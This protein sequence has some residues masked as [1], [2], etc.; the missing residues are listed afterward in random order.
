MKANSAVRLIGIN[1]T[2]D[3]PDDFVNLH[4]I[5]QF[6][7]VLD[8]M[9]GLTA[10]GED[11]DKAQVTGIINLPRISYA[12]K[13]RLTARYPEVN[14]NAE[15]VICC[16]QFMNE[17]ADETFV[18]YEERNVVSGH[19]TAEPITP[20]RNPTASTVYTFNHWYFADDPAKT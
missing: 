12:D 3:D 14:I 15:Q 10:E 19:A 8:T 18:L 7:D 16:V 5:E 1:E 4:K 20:T 2:Y 9:K 17:V 13:V 6:Y 11:T